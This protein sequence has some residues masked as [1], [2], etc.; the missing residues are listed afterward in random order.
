M[1][2]K[3]MFLIGMTAGCIAGALGAAAA[4][5]AMHP[6]TMMRDGR[7]MMRKARKCMRGLC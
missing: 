7:K 1:G 6:G 3:G 2:V 4:V 5:E